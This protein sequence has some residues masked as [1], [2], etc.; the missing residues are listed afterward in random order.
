M[1]K[2]VKTTDSQH[3]FPVADNVLRRRFNPSSPNK[4]WASD[5][6]YLHTEEGFLFL[7]VILDLF[8]RRVVGYSLAPHMRTEFCLDALKMAKG[9]SGIVK[10]VVHHSDRGSQYASHA[11]RNSLHED[12]IICSMSRKGNCWDNA[13]AESFFATL[14]TELTY[15]FHWRTRSELEREVV[16]YIHWYNGRRRHSSLEY[17]SPVQYEREYYAAELAA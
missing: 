4:A 10:D 14:K 11:Y 9:V 7:C 5:I 13:V 1:R 16:K 6:T 2:R 15:R 3:D 12:D 8:S 17:K